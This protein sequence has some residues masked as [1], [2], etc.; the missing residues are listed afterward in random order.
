[1]PPADLHAL[2]V[3]RNQH[4]GD[5]QVLASAEQTLG[6]LHLHGQAEHGADG[7]EGDVALVP[8]QPQAQHLPPV[9]LLFADDP[10]VGHGRGVRAG[11]GTGQAEGGDFASVRE[12]RQ[13]VLLLFIRAELQEK[14]A[15][16]KRVGHHHRD[17][18]RH[19][20]G[21]DLPHHFGVCV[22]G[23][24]Q[25][26][27]FLGDDHPE[28]ALALDEVPGLRRQVALFPGDL[29][30]VEHGAQLLDRPVDEGSLLGR[31]LGRRDVQELR[32]VRIA[33]EEGRIP[34]DVAGGDGLG[35][36]VGHLGQDALGHVVDGPR[37]KVAAQ[38]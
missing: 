29:P 24:A 22:R 8:V 25:T 13:P 23:E 27:E 10:G 11:L 2:R 3:G 26:A 16:A 34:P 38:G 28:E 4:H 5:A 9:A 14:L 21:G 35:L 20:T 19:G 18:G 32:P 30:V 33:R 37:D 6:I 36:G 12:T 7:A 1:M 15:G 17:G 31:Q